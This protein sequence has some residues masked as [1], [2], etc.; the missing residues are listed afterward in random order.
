[1][2]TSKVLYFHF[3]LCLLTP[4]IFAEQ[5]TVL[6]YNTE[7]GGANPTAIAAAMLLEKLAAM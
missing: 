2:F 4:S 7:S 3:A 6:S 1:M 5:I